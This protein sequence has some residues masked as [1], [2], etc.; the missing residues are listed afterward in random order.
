MD[1]VQGHFAAAEEALRAN[2]ASEALAQARAVLER[3]PGNGRAYALV[4]LAYAAMGEETEARE[5]L[6]HAESLWPLDART[7]YY[8]YLAYARMREMAEARKQL[9]YFTQLE[10]KNAAARAALARLG[11]PPAD[12]PPLPKQSGG[13]LW[14]DAGGRALADSSEVAAEALVEGAEPPPGPNV[15][16]CPEC[17]KRTFRG[18]CCGQ[19][20][21]LLP[22][23]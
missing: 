23:E 13:V 10:P 17:G 6:R 19:C 15:I 12:L 2:R 11:G 7:R 22:R 16:V 14:F 20:G 3:Q 18:I 1:P 9:A 21:A 5:A 4:G 8:A